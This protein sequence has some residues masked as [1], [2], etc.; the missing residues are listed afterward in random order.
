[1]QPPGPPLGDLALANFLI[2]PPV[3]IRQP[4]VDLLAARMIGVPVALRG[5]GRDRGSKQCG[6]E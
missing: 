5:R 1:V 3:L 4:V 2:D 6:S